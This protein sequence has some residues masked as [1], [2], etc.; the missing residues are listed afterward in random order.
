MEKVEGSMVEGYEVYKSIYYAN[1]YI[2]K[3]DDTLGKVVLDDQLD[4][5]K[6]EEELLQ[7]DQKRHIIKSKLLIFCQIIYTKKL[8]TL[9][10]ITYIWSHIT[11]PE[12]LYTWAN[13][14]TNAINKNFLY[15]VEKTQPWVTLYEEK[16]KKWDSDRK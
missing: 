2:K 14:K 5:D 3:I 16:R 13:S 15:N 1:E 9:K 12:F 6:R 8:F 10:L 7:M 4:E 11:C